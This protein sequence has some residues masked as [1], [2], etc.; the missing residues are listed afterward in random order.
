MVLHLIP[1][2]IVDHGTLVGFRASSDEAKEWWAANVDGECPRL[3]DFFL[4]EHRYARDIL[5]GIRR[6]LG[7]QEED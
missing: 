1:F 7:T 3:G 6:D 5:D 4:V 2:E